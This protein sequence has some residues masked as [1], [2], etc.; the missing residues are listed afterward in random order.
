MFEK[1]P[2]S[3]MQTARKTD[4][5]AESGKEFIFRLRNGTEIARAKS[6]SDFVAK[7]KTVPVESIEYHLYARHFSPWLRYL[8]MNGLADSLEHLNSRGEKLRQEILDLISK[9]W[10]G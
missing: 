7:I 3:S 2:S 8:K 5:I 9:F 6:L 10:L 1:F 4:P